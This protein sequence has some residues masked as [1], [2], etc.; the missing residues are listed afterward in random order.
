MLQGRHEQ[1]RDTLLKLHT[2]EEVEV[3]FLQIRE[4][5]EIDKTLPSSY[6]AMFANKNNRKRTLIGMGT[7]ASIQTSGILVINS[8]YPKFLCT[9]A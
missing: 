1:A 7:F 6:W 9:I 2:P 4:Q 8:Q 5:V 3:E